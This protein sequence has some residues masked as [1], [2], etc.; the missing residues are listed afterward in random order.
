MAT[1]TQEDFS[2]LSSAIASLTEALG[3]GQENTAA[4]TKEFKKNLIGL[5]TELLKVADA[6]RKFGQTIGVS[7]TSG[8]EL[9][10]KNRAQAVRQIISLE[11]NR[12]ASLS[13]IQAVEKSLADTFI[14]VRDGFKF[15]AQGAAQLASNLKGGFGSEFELTGESLRALTV[16]G[17]TTTEQFTAFRQ[18]TGRASLSSNQLATIVNKNSL[19][20]LL[21]GNRFAKAAADAEKIGISL[22]SI[23]SAQA[24]LV[25]NLEGTIDTVAQL[26]Q[27]GGQI[28]F[29]TLTRIAEQEGPD[30][31]LAY[32][33]ATVPSEF[34]KSTSFRALFEQLGVSSEQL[35][36][37]GQVRTTAD[38]LDSQLSQL[39]TNATATSKALAA[40]SSAADAVN[41]SFG[42]LAKQIVASAAGTAIGGGAL[43]GLGKALGGTVAAFAAP[44]IAAVAATAA[45]G[46]GLYS[47]FKGDDVIS[48]Y[49]ER[50]LVTPTGAVALNNNDTVLAGTRLMSQGALQPGDTSELNRKVDT[51]IATLQ[52]ANTT[53]NIDGTMRTVPRMSLVGVYSRNE[54]A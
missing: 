17:A 41:S 22:A 38:N 15:S 2:S 42:G 18:A 25:T 8:I 27:L 31:L 30:A 1:P 37:A 48:G 6:G 16:I 45:V 35:L 46:Y 5:G 28:D 7:A 34:F 40:L 50:T 14:G 29:G 32:L 13:Q 33:R 3:K 39:G 11:A 19:S 23:Q 24:G 51:L 10:L 21:Y 26:N 43:K 4:G 44:E 20:F 52:N 9:E 54:R 47:L 12:A 53:I 36:R 49:G